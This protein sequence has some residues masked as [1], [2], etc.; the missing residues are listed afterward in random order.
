M[1]RNITTGIEIDAPPARVWEVLTDFAAYGEWNPFIVSAEGTP[2][3]GGRL[4]LRMRADGRTFTVRPTV[5]E[6]VEGRLLRWVGRLWVGGL[7][8]AEHI[9]SIE[10]TATGVWYVQQEFFRGALLPFLGKTLAATQVAFERMNVALKH[11]V[12][13]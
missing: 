10:A 6:A 2:N 7:F 13:Q 12:E 3:T 1:S 8:D 9:H 11:R 4:K 5:V